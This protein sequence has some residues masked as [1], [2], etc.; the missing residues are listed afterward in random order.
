MK[1]EGDSLKR[2]RE[3]RLEIYEEEKDLSPQE[4]RLRQYERVKAFLS[5]YGKRIGSHADSPR[6]QA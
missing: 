4:A 5:K 6:P 1:R 3:I 2:I